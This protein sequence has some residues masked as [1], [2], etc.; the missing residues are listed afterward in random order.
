MRIDDLLNQAVDAHQAGRLD[1]AQSLYDAVLTH[2]PDNANA[3]NLLGVMAAVRGAHTQAIGYFDRAIAGRASFADAYF[4][5]GNSRVALGQHP[6]A[7]VNFRKTIELDPQHAGAWLNLGAVLHA[8]GHAA[9]AAQVFRDMAQ[10]RPTDARA[11][12]NLGRCLLD[13]RDYPQAEAALR[14][15]LALV[16]DD[17]GVRITLSKLLM[18]TGR[19]QD[20]RALLEETLRFTPD[21][22]DVLRALGSALGACGDS[23]G[24]LAMYDRALALLPNDADTIVNRGITQL[25]VGNLAEGWKGYARRFDSTEASF[26]Y[27]RRKTPWPQWQ[28]ENLAG[29]AILIWGEQGVGDQILY[30]SMLP[31]VIAKAMACI[32]ECEARLQPLFERAFPGVRVISASDPADPISSMQIDVQSSSLDLGRWLR[33]SFRHFPARQSYLAPDP[34]RVAA[35]REKY[36]SLRDGGRRLVGISWRSKSLGAGEEKTVPLSAW[37]PILEMPGVAFVSVQ[38]GDVAA[39]LTEAKSHIHVDPEVNSLKDLDT[40]AAQL[41]AL[42][43]V[44]SVS[45]T[46]VHVAG[47]IGVPTWVIVPQ[48]RGGLWYW[49]DKGEHSPWYPSVRLF[50]QNVE[51]MQEIAAALA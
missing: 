30:A 25:S 16:P 48:G 31:D 35:F 18:E 6:E 29:K 27:R 47:S 19:P 12:F 43:L 40:F 36:A 46:A 15:A 20:A 44:I 45:N 42:D 24:A 17:R 14:A 23:A 37:K 34:A 26:A 28:G 22:G 8:A 50:R 3:L 32:V 11:H 49:F 51:T 7:E 39:D 41:A 9:A 10:R 4:N 5:R 13:A 2:E 1:E 21:A 38:Y 33:P